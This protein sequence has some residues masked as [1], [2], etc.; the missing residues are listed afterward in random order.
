MP[1][2]NAATMNATGVKFGHPDTLVAEFSH[3]VVLLRPAQVT[4]GSLVLLCTDEAERFGD[5]SAEAVTELRSSD[6]TEIFI[7]W[8]FYQGP[9]VICTITGKWSEARVWI[10]ST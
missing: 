5:I 9:T 8:R 7:R 6:P 10:T 2:G 4:L 1:A 3:W